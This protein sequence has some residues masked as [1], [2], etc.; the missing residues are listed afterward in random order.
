[1]KKRRKAKPV[2]EEPEP[3]FTEEELQ[4]LSDEADEQERS[5]Q[6]NELTENFE[7]NTD[8]A[9]RSIPNY[10]DN[11]LGFHLEINDTQAHRYEKVDAEGNITY[12]FADINRDYSNSNL[13]GSEIDQIRIFNTLLQLCKDI[14]AEDAGVWVERKIFAMIATSRG[15]NGF[16]RRMTVS[17]FTHGSMKSENKTIE[18]KP[19]SFLLWAKKKKSGNSGEY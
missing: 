3:E 19:S 13:V 14:G 8:G 1:M 10:I 12:P 4:K 16:E 7:D 11:D 15:R 6:L 17:Q 2:L 5:E 18:D 9:A